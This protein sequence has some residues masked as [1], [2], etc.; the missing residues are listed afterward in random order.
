MHPREVLWDDP[1][2]P[3]SAH[4]KFKHFLQQTYSPFTFLNAGVDTAY[5]RVTMDRHY[6][7]GP[8]GW[9]S[10]FGVTVADTEARSMFSWW[11]FPTLLHQDPRYLPQ[12]RGGVISRGWHAASHVLVTRNDDGRVVFNSSGMLGIAFWAALAN[13]YNPE[14]RGGPDTLSR[15]AGAM[16][17]DASGYVLREFWPDISRIF[18]RH[19]PKSLKEIEKRIP[20]P[21]GPASE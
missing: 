21:A 9:A 12:R 19:E 8:T 13:A 20:M 17:G 6:G 14:Q 2:V 11:I 10:Q 15:M 3:L 4:Q 16:E 1:Y 5:S 18:R 7:G